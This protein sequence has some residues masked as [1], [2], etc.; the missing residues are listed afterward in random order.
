MIPFLLEGSASW[1]R[2]FQHRGHKGGTEAHREENGDVGF[3]FLQKNLCE[4]LCLL[5]ALCVEK[6]ETNSHFRQVGR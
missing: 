2:F 5:C 6:N 3:S 1:S 4:P